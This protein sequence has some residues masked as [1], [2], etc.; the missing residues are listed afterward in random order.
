MN[1]ESTIKNKASAFYDED[2]ELQV[3]VPLHKWLLVSASVLV[4]LVLPMLFI[5]SSLGLI[6]QQ[7]YEQGSMFSDT[8]HSYQDFSSNIL[9]NGR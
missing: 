2:K 4:F 6:H 5:W 3:L 9:V 1:K 8:D 7:G